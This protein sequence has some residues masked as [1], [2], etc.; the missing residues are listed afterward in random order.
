MKAS[1]LCSLD[2]WHIFWPPVNREGHIRSKHTS[3]SHK[4]KSDPLVMSSVIDSCWERMRKQEVEWTFR[5]NIV[6]AYS[7]SSKASPVL[8]LQERKKRKWKPKEE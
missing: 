4:L 5:A 7:E 2:S 8:S 3:Y 1:R 6:I